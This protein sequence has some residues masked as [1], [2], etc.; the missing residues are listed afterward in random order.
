MIERNRG[1]PPAPDLLDDAGLDFLVRAPADEFVA[2]LSE[3]GRDL[4][5]LAAN[6]GAAV[7]RA[8]K[9]H[10]AQRLRAQLQ[11]LA[12]HPLPDTRAGLLE[13]AG[14]LHAAAASAG[15]V[16]SL[17]QTD[18]DPLSDEQLRTLISRLQDI[19]AE[20]RP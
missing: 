11:A 12:S 20:F 1:M 9:A 15:L 18:L 3:E 16:V 13:M 8:L 4:E 2:L 17:Q 19:C 5:A 6:A 10:D 7:A 14:Q